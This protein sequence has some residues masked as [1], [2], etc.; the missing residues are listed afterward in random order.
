MFRRLLLAHEVDYAVE[1]SED[2][3]TWHARTESAGDPT[4][5]PDGSLTATLRD[6]VPLGS[7]S[8]RFLRLSVSRLPQ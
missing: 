3:I 5:N 6:T 1:V 2:L 4:L 7:A 8:A